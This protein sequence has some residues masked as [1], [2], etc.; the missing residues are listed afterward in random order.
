MAVVNEEN[1]RTIVDNFF[2]IGK[3]LAELAIGI[4]FCH[5]FLLASFQDFSIV[6]S[7]S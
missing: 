3:P 7:S 2:E 4:N 1:D 6:M 5:L